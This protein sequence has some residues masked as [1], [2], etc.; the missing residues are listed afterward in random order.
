MEDDG[1]GGVPPVRWWVKA[2]GTPRDPVGCPWRDPTRRSEIALP[3]GQ[4]ARLMPGDHALLY[5][6]GHGTIFAAVRI[7]SSFYEVPG[8]AFPGRLRIEPLVEDDGFEVFLDWPRDGLAASSYICSGG[9]CP[10]ESGST[11]TSA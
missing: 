6:V 5:A 11:P 3:A 7:I 2:I 4:V 1:P 8:A 10:F 9:R